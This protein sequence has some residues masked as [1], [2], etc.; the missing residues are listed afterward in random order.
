MK[1]KNRLI[2]LLLGCVFGA[3]AIAGASA[4]KPETVEGPAERSVSDV[5]AYLDVRKEA[6]GE[7]YV[8][9][10]NGEPLEWEQG[11]EDAVRFCRENGLAADSFSNGNGISGKQKMMFCGDIP[12]VDESS[13][14]LDQ[15][16][17]PAVG[18]LN[19]VRMYTDLAL[20]TADE[21][22]EKAQRVYEKLRTYLGKTPEVVTVYTGG[23]EAERLPLTECNVS[24]AVKRMMKNR[25][26][27]F[28][29]VSVHFDNLSLD[30]EPWEDYISV[31]IDLNILILGE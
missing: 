19:T 20:E 16:G 17:G 5:T 7:R 22:A 28:A 23:D 6:E 30:I 10:V 8:L 21:A 14:Y 1:R 27:E 18:K 24:D 31:K 9:L 13:F 26:Q 12:L 4:E 29:F 3:A 25:Q 15:G 2:A 11:I